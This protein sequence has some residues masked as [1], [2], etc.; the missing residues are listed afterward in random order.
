MAKPETPR[1]EAILPTSCC[2][3]GVVP[4]MNT[5][6]A[7]G[8]GKRSACS[9]RGSLS[10]RSSRAASQVAVGRG[11]MPDVDPT[12]A[13]TDRPS[14]APAMREERK[15]VTVLFADLAGSTA[16]GERMDPEE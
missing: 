6:C 5:S 2:G 3:S 11:R 12:D 13:P 7:P 10:P 1:S 14:Q 15:V 4:R 9:V 8:K 16:L